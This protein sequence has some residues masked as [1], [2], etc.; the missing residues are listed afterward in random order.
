MDTVEGFRVAMEALYKACDAE[1]RDPKTVDVNLLPTNINRNDSGA[2]IPFYG[3]AAQTIDDIRA[4]EAEGMTGMTMH[5]QANDLSQSLE[6][7][8]RFA[9]DVMPHIK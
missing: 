3:E 7:M 1:K 8:Q 4:Y 5:F 2:R 9:E 6:N